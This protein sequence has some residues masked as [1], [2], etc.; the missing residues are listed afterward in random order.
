M[1]PFLIFLPVLLFW[2]SA[3]GAVFDGWVVGEPCAAELRIADC[4]LRFSDRSMLLLED[5]RR[6]AFIYGDGKSL[7]P[8][9]VDKAY[10]KKVRMAGEV[11]DGVLHAVRLDV[12]EITG[13]RKF[14]KGCL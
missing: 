4:P 12:Q 3:S 13:E 6:L 1:R 9:A 8:E 7:T 14:F 5:G 11:K 10:G 2:T